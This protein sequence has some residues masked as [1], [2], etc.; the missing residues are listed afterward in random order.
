MKLTKSQLKHIIKEELSKLLSEFDENPGLN[1]E[2]NGQ[3][4]E[5]KNF[6]QEEFVEEAKYDRGM[7]MDEFDMALE[8]FEVKYNL[9]FPDSVFKL[10]DVFLEMNED[11]LANRLKIMFEPAFEDR[12][13]RQEEEEY[14]RNFE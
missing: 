1:K 5:M 11:S 9:D 13:F 8:K 3:D 12:E 6:V 2:P 4:Q 7:S 10:Y 14:E